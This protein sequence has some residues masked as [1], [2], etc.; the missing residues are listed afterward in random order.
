MTPPLRIAGGGLAGSAAAC[1]LAQAGRQV[2]V[3]ERSTVPHHKICGEFLSVEAQFYLNR[4]GLDPTRLGGHP[5]DRVRLVQGDRAVEARLPFQGLGLTRF[6]LDD[7][8]L[9]HAEASGATIRRGESVAQT[10]GITFL[11]TGKHDL[12]DARR[13]AAEPE[14]LIGFKILFRLSPAEQAALAHAV[15]VILF[16][17]GYAG[18][19]R[20]EDGQANLCLLIHRNRFSHVGGRWDALLDDL[21]R[22]SP[23]LAR[24]LA[25]AEPLLDR[26]LTIARVPY[27][28]IH[29]ARPGETLYRLGDQACVIPSFS[30][31]GMAMALHSAALAVSCHIAGRTPAEYHA[32]LALHVTGPIDRAG[33]LYRLGRSAP[34]QA[35]LLRA[36][37]LWPG[38]LRHAAR[39][40]RL[41]PQAWMNP[42][43]HAA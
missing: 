22:A 25:D 1:Q 16:P 28:F 34:G 18:L 29:R 20:V 24:R 36:V 13:A 35:W 39:L 21:C 12:R 27:G 43:G 15:E 3:I 41:P 19:Q 6:T 32:R 30:G 9:R 17:D 5:I 33:H 8:L 4:L 40:T 42:E 2:T 11:A 38:L 31:D 7:A 26:P 23:H 37:R 14:A 10:D